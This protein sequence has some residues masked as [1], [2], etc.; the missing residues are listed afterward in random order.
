MNSFI[1][2]INYFNGSENLVQLDYV[3]IEYILP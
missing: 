2:R 1:I 3:H